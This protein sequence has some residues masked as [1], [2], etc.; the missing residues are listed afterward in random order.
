M[1]KTT[2]SRTPDLAFTYLYTFRWIVV[3]AALF[4]AGIAWV[5]QLPGLFAACVTIGIGEWLECSYY[6]SVLRWQ[7]HRGRPTGR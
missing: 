2:L 4:G 1:T 6:L 3:S 7:Q 5:E